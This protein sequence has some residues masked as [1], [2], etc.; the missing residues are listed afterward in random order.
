MTSHAYQSKSVFLSKEPGE[1]YA[2]S[3]RAQAHDG[4]AVYGFDLAGHGHQ[5]DED[6][7]Q[8]RPGDLG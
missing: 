3:D 4:R 2:Y 5:P 1:D 7:G 6:R 8:G